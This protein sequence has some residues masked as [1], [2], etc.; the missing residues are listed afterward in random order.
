MPMP[1]P[2]GH[3]CSITGDTIITTKLKPPWAHFRLHRCLRRHLETKLDNPQND[4]GLPPWSFVRLN[5]SYRQ[6]K[7][8]HFADWNQ[9]KLCITKSAEQRRRS[10]YYAIV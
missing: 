9:L 6:T 4:N 3:F 10:V 2:V 8:S 1:P 5:K 7:H